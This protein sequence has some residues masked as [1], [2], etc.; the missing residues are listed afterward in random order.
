MPIFLG[1]DFSGVSELYSIPS[2]VLAPAGLVVLVSSEPFFEDIRGSTLHQC[3]E[4]KAS[5][6][7]RLGIF[8]HGTKVHGYKSPTVVHFKGKKCPRCKS[9][10]ACERSLS[11]QYQAQVLCETELAM[12]L[13]DEQRRV[14]PGRETQPGSSQWTRRWS[15][16]P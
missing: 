1:H 5:F 16:R 2:A 7:T 8:L 3:S 14:R 9:V 11:P 4:C 10:F 13:Q 12:F 15:W 6:S